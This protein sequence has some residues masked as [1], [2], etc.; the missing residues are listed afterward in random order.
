[1]AVARIEELRFSYPERAEPALD[2][3]SL[4]LQ[5]GEIVAVLGPS[6]SGKSTL[7]RA[8]AGLVPHFH[9]GRFAGRV[10]VGGLDTRRATPA[11]LAG[12]VATVFQDPEDQIV[13][14]QV[15]NEVAFGLENLAVAPATIWPR[16]E[17][18]LDRLGIAA[19]ADRA[20]ATLSGGELQRLCLAAALAVE[21][22][23]LV[24][25]EPSS[26]LDEDGAD[27]LLGEIATLCAERGTAVVLS[28]HRVARALRHCHRVLFL[29]RGQI[30]LDAPRAE[31]LAWLARERPAY[32][33]GPRVRPPAAPAGETVCAL[34]GVS[35]AYDEP[36][37]QD[38]SLTLR[39]GEVVGLL[40]PNGVG[41]TTLAKLAAGL[42]EPQA[43][44]VERSGRACYLS[45][46]P[47]RYLVTE[48]VLAEVA[49]AAPENAARGA[50]ESVDLAAYE[51][52]H[53][54]DLSSGERERVALAA[55]LAP[56]P[57]LLVLD[58]PTR[59]VDPPRKA[60]LAAL[61]RAQAP[62]RATL[63]VTHD[64]DLAAA[65]CDSLLWLSADGLGTGPDADSAA[66]I[67]G[68]VPHPA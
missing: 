44:S 18:A 47:G 7:L 2:G 42:L 28:E 31:A 20:V 64:L 19:L 40:G 14:A 43:G 54:R 58:E 33:P 68:D 67:E 51:T 50:L 60:A 13:L 9:G 62:E 8:L 24:L 30:L 45:Q 35:F 36:L 65:V 32:V 3:V 1:M 27:R 41:K 29:E 4:V 5:P 23:L 6:G 12:T 38:V 39:R 53:P 11:E 52:R 49:L 61:L 34:A 25:D 10:V 37:L 15:R 57:E 48:T 66:S 21:P 55:V 46:D 26:Q 63:L 59:G 22:Q 56:A 16:V 17:A